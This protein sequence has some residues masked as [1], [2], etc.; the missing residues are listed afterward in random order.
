MQIRKLSK[1]VKPAKVLSENRHYKGVSEFY[2]IVHLMIVRFIHVF[3]SVYL[4]ATLIT[5]N[6]TRLSSRSFQFIF[7]TSPAELLN[8]SRMLFDG[9]ITRSS[10]NISSPLLKILLKLGLVGQTSSAWGIS[11]Q[12]ML[13]SSIASL[14]FSSS[15]LASFVLSDFP[16]SQSRWLCLSWFTSALETTSSVSL[17]DI[18]FLLTLLNCWKSSILARGYFSVGNGRM[19]TFSSGLSILPQNPPPPWCSPPHPQQK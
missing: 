5:A 15:I 17:L 10:A 18:G 13:N 8:I 6:R 12:Q 3:K 16:K 1:K 19:L 2:V 9:N 4:E 11:S 7:S 14:T